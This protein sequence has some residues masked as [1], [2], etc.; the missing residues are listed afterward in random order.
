MTISI[1][2]DLYIIQAC[3]ARLSVSRDLEHL[4]AVHALIEKGAL[5]LFDFDVREKSRLLRKS[6]IVINVT[7]NFYFRIDLTKRMDFTMKI[8]SK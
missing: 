4:E 3:A 5:T 6:R 8:N 2:R 7:H 1:S